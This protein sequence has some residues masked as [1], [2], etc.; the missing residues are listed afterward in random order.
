MDA[1]APLLAERSI[2]SLPPQPA[3]T[4]GLHWITADKGRYIFSP[5]EHGTSTV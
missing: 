2:V 5:H 1:R 3:H 4:A